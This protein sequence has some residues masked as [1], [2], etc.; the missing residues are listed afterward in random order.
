MRCSTT[1]RGTN[2]SVR[3]TFCSCMV[4]MVEALYGTSTSMR[5]YMC[6]TDVRTEYVRTFAKKMRSFRNIFH[7]FVSFV[8]SS[9][10]LEPVRT[11]SD[12][13]G[14][15]RMHFWEISKNSEKILFCTFLRSFLRS[16][17]QTDVTSSFLDVF[18]S[19]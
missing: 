13:F 14:C 11:C 6:C 1:F 8:Q 10:L 18:C 2:W 5:L 17:T 9:E 19:T 15:V 3:Y 4:C 12:G 7:N 16:Y